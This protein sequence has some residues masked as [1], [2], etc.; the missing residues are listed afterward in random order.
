[1][2]SADLDLNTTDP[3]AIR[4]FIKSTD[5]R[6]GLRVIFT[7]YQSGK[8]LSQALKGITVDFAVYDEVHKALGDDQKLF[9]HLLLDKNFKAQKK[10]F[11]TATPKVSQ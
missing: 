10:W 2:L 7:T 1:M 4:N 6:E 11:I 5:G 8:K 9:S 3:S